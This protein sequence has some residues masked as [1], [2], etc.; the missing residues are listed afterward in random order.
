MVENDNI[1]Y[2]KI[3]INKN[4]DFIGIGF[5]LKIMQKFVYKI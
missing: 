4:M 1:M 5:F 2:I 3:H